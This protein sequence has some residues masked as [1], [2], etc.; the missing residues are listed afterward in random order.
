MAVAT[1]IADIR[2][3]KVALF[4]DPLGQVRMRGI[5]AGVDQGNR[6]MAAARPALRPASIA[7]K[8]VCRAA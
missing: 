1:R 7:E 6:D 8:P 2:A 3:D 5:D 4:D